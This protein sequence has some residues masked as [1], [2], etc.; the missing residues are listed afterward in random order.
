MKRAN[1]PLKQG[2]KS[3]GNPWNQLGNPSASKHG[4]FVSGITHHFDAPKATQA[5][6][7]LLKTSK[8]NRL[9]KI[10]MVKMLYDAD[11]DQF[12]R[13][14]S[15]ITGDAPYSMEHGPILSKIL[16][17]LDGKSK[18]VTWN[19][20]IVAVDDKW[21]GL[22]T[23]P[24]EDLLNASEK[25]SLRNAWLKLKDLSF[26]QMEKLFHTEYPEWEDP[27]KSCKPIKP[28]TILER[29]GKDKKFIAAIVAQQGEDAYMKKLFG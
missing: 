14:G 24:E 28:E 4:K 7:Y 26:S 5:A 3:A 27:G 16:S 6:G 13:T 12:T 18:N 22:A 11:R 10:Y 23:K 2:L 19:S 8:G 1:Q 9:S 17:L 15:T 25:E 29:A 20:T 21:F